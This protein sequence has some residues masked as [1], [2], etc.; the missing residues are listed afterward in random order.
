MDSD[1]FFN[2]DYELPESVLEDIRRVEKISKP[3]ADENDYN[4]WGP[5][6]VSQSIS[7]SIPNTSQGF[8]FVEDDFKSNSKIA[9]RCLKS[10]PNL[11]AVNENYLLTTSRMLTSDIELLQIIELNKQYDD[12]TFCIN[13]LQGFFINN[14]YTAETLAQKKK[15]IE[16][17]QFLD[18]AGVITR[19]LVDY[20]ITHS[21]FCSNIDVVPLL[22][23][24]YI[25]QFQV[26]NSNHIFNLHML[27]NING[28]RMQSIVEMLSNEDWKTQYEHIK[29]AL[30]CNFALIEKWIKTKGPSFY[31]AFK[32]L[33]NI[34]GFPKLLSKIL[35]QCGSLFMHGLLSN[36]IFFFN[37]FLDPKF[38]H[39]IPQFQIIQ[40][41]VF[42]SGDTDVMMCL[43]ENDDAILSFVE[44]FENTE[45][46]QD[47]IGFIK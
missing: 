31:D 38:I 23:K 7:T 36:H 15:K 27:L 17:Y 6:I 9:L 12:K 32:A 14:G 29:T 30:D 16:S 13:V 28:A 21:F 46:G 11:S 40:D 39:L 43:F 20:S 5:D 37:W 22:I 47:P 2:E 8:Q 26:L 24:Y 19:F 33:I 25:G 1:E 4:A 18:T 10:D 3:I 41:I 34:N 42:A 45:F 44:I 35:P